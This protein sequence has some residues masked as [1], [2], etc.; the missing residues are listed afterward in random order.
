MSKDVDNGSGGDLCVLFYELLH[1][2]TKLWLDDCIS[3]E[4][5]CLIFS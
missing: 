3:G 1:L 4:A 5:F 2:R